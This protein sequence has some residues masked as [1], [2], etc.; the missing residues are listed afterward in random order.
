MRNASLRDPH[1]LGIGRSLIG[2]MALVG[3]VQLLA[4]TLAVQSSLQ[5]FRST[6]TLLRDATLSRTLVL[7]TDFA[8]RERNLTLI[9]LASPGQRSAARL[10]ELDRAR[11]DGDRL[12]QQALERMNDGERR[13]PREVGQQLAGQWRQFTSLRPDSDHVLHDAGAAGDETHRFLLTLATTRLF[14]VTGQALHE[15]TRSLQSTD[16]V[17]VAR[18]AQANY[19][20][21][22]ARETAE[23]EGIALVLRSAAQRPLNSTDEGQIQQDRS[24]VDYLLGQLQIEARFLGDDSLIRESAQLVRRL[25]DVRRLGDQ[26][27]EL[28]RNGTALPYQERYYLDNAERNQE[29]FLTLFNH[30]DSRLGRLIDVRRTDYRQQLVRDAALAALALAL[31]LLLLLWLRRRVLAPLSLLKTIQDAT[32]EAI[33]LALP[34]G[35]IYLANVGAE[36]LWQMDKHQLWHTPL[37]ELLPGFALPAEA[38]AVETEA[39]RSDGSR[40]MTRAMASRITLPG[41]REGTLLVIRDEHMRHQAEMRERA[42]QQVILSITYIQE[43]LFHPL[44]ASGVFYDLLSVMLFHCAASEG[45]LIEVAHR[46]DGDCYRVHAA[47]T[48]LL[49]A[50]AATDDTQPLAGLFETLSPRDG[51]VLWPVAP[52]EDISGIVCLK[53][54]TIDG[55]ESILEPL[56]GAYGSILGFV[57]NETL[58]RQSEQQVRD[59]L[60]E[61]EAM[62]SAS[63]TGLLLLNRQH[64]IVRCNPAVCAQFDMP[65]QGLLGLHPTLLLKDNAAWETLSEQLEQASRDGTSAVTELPCVSV[66]G[67]PLWMLF[68]IRRLYHDQPERGTLVACVDITQSK[69]GELALRQ[70][71][72]EA[73]ESRQRMVAAIEATP[74]P[75]AFYDESDCLVQCNELYAQLFFGDTVSSDLIGQTFEQLVLRS[76]Q[77]GELMDPGFGDKKS[78]V[79]ERI[80]RHRSGNSTYLLKLGNRWLQASDRHIPGLG[81]VCLRAD[82]TEMKAREEE[83]F[84][85]KNQ[86][87]AA[88]KAKS[89]F[90]ASIS[91]EIRTPMNGVMG[92]LEMLSLS[93]LDAEQK[94]T[95]HTAQEA[96]HSLLRLI[97]DILDFSKI[98]AGKLDLVMATAPIPA[99]MEKVRSLYQ[100]QIG[101]KGLGFD[102]EIDPALAPCHHVDPLRLRQILQ[103]FVSNA[104]KFT[105]HG[106]IRLSVQVMATLDEQQILC[107]SCCDTGIGISAENLTRLFQPFTQAES[108]TT[109][110]FGGTGLGLAISRR[111]ADLMDGSI[112]LSSKPGQGTTARLILTLDTAPAQEAAEEAVAIALPRGQQ[113][114][115][116]I[117]FAEDNPTN[118]KLT[119]MQLE[120]IGIP[121]EV[122]ENGRQAL[123]MWLAAGGYSLVLTDFHMPEMDGH[124]LA[125]A[126]RELEASQPPAHPVPIIAYT[127][128]AAREEAEDARQAGIDEV[129]T[130]PIRIAELE[131]CLRKWLSLGAF[132]GHAPAP[133]A[134]QAVAPDVAQQELAATQAA[135]LDR[136][137]LSIYS[138]GDRE[139]ENAIIAEF[140]D[141]DDEDM[142]GLQLAFDRG[143]HA[144]VKWFCHRIKGAA[145]MVGAL[146]LSE[147]AREMEA[148]AAREADQSQAWQALNTERAALEAWFAREN[149]AQTVR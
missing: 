128:N 4:F 89:A 116:P 49:E 56:L 83:L 113:I 6:T 119:I 93:R 76:I 138:Q 110:R 58:R 41:K 142:S 43:R 32:Q 101:A 88:N 82:V 67:Q 64:I 38:A 84:L 124:Q 133:E 26:Q 87:D 122:A 34:D 136:E 131:A 121:C 27:L 140:M 117:L 94:D 13:P 19:M 134:M 144:A 30:A 120:R 14:D 145:A 80:R 11:R 3:L 48:P 72:D 123:D 12:M 28:L 77:R 112:D 17:D 62:F 69:L 16:S 100:D 90:L 57:A 47:A 148:L 130:K 73:A 78:W 102:I 81:V 24:E 99:L 65:D 71:R 51:W 111:L 105:E 143:D 25:F 50:S 1:P 31:N 33:I 98:E 115:R 45:A 96:A 18:L 108:D 147:C 68:E 97:D 21:W 85:A 79:E 149:G 20:L 63:P 40:L 127:A 5:G 95:L 2:I 86:A 141:S 53:S 59:V 118:R 61:Q 114:A 135:P 39:L 42:H 126:I 23:G 75:F 29:A 137:A 146:A 139:V 60:A 129:L 125:R 109:R 15:L 35:R 55:M 7:A 46:D 66:S 107:F 10:G 91:H 70:A 9:M 44:E 8:E 74:Q 52:S 104:L 22:R 54:P 92:L 106:S 36:R 37:A 132:D 103:N